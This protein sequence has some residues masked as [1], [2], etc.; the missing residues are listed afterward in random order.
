MTFLDSHSASLPVSSILFLLTQ[1][2]KS[3]FGCTAMAEKLLR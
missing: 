3:L 1:K 2:Y